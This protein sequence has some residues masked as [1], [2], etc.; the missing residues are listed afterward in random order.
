MRDFIKNSWQILLVEILVISAFALFFGKFGDIM[1]D[2]FREVYIPQQILK[3]KCIYKDIFVIYPP[4]AYLINAF[5]MKIFGAGINILYLAGLFSTMG[6]F[7]FTYK[8]AKIFL[9]EFESFTICIFLITGLALSPNVFNSF[10][11]YSYG[12]VYGILFVIASL[13]FALNK[14]F[15]L[16]YLFYSLAILCKY[17]LCFCVKCVKNRLI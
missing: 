7:F 14:K 17:E 5:L 3:G 2:S 11:P 4:L 15:P 1:I 9:N 13:Y 6:I 16:T 8:I 12:I 10:F